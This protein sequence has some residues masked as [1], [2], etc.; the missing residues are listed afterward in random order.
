MTL[1]QPVFRFL[2]VA[3]VALTTASCGFAL[4]DSYNLPDEVTQVSLTSVDPYGELTRQLRN[5]LNQHKVELV[6]PANTVTNIHLLGESNSEQ[7]LSLYQNS[8][9]AEKE[10]RYVARYRVTVPQKGSYTF[11][12][13]LSRNFLDNPLTALAKSV[14]QD[15]LV[16][17]MRT[18]ATRQIMR[19]LSQLKGDIAEFERREA[20]QA[21]LEQL[22]QGE[23]PNKPEIIIETRQTETDTA[24]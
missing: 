22:E 20:E 11:S 24:Q 14:E 16:A 13:T 12:T 7:T 6:A 23:R 5:Q 3:V 21:A 17:E 10:F 18:E 9:V 15:K 4:R 19:Q 2:L 1:F 8:R